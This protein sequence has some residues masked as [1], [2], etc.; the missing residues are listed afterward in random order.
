MKEKTATAH[1]EQSTTAPTKR[2]YK[3]TPTPRQRRAARIMA[4]I[5]MG[6]RPDIKNQGDIVIAA[7]YSPATAVIPGKLLNTIGVEIALAD[8][9]FNPDTA[10]KVV[11]E[12]L[13]SDKAMHKDRLKAA[14]MVFKVHGT[15]AAEKHVSLNVDANVDTEAMLALAERLRNTAR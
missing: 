5:A 10:K 9:G 6:K 15:Y 8:N 7:G 14:D 12:I 3:L 2:K 11:N 1:T 4:D 13:T